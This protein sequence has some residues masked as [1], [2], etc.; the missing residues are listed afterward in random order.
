MSDI[1]TTP[2][3]NDGLPLLSFTIPQNEP[4]QKCNAIIR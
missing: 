1:A 4:T 2:L 3:G